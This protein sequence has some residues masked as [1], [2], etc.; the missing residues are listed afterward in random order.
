VGTAP[1]WAEGPGRPSH[2]V[3]PPGSWKP[4]PRPFGEFARALAT[5]YS[6]AFDPPG[7]A[8]TLPK[9]RHYQALNE[10]NLSTYLSP[11][12]SG[13]RAVSPSHYRA[14]LNDFYPQ[15]KSVDPGNMVL[16]AGTAPYGARPGGKRMPPLRFWR[17]L[18]CV[19][20]KRGRYRP[21]QRCANPAQVDIVA[22]HPITRAPR[23]RAAHAGDVTIP[24]LSQL[25]RVVRAAERGR[26]VLPAGRRPLWV[27][28]LWWETNPPDRVVRTSLRRQARWIAEGLYLIWKQ[29]IPV[30]IL[31]LIRDQPY[32]PALPRATFQS[33]VY[34]ENGR[35]KPALRAA[36]FPFVARRR[37]PPRLAVWGRSPATG[38]LTIQRRSAGKWRRLRRLRV[39]SG[40]VFRATVGVRGPA[41]LRARVAGQRSAVWRQGGRR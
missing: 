12:W 16:S 18:L 24:E 29:R 6:G 15:V 31:F 9:V 30:T 41:V 14:L 37:S 35:P 32:L 33:G 8:P 25:R 17:S 36:R 28:E 21:R 11:Q 19:K 22:H 39:Q 5:R 4:Y 27:T 13:R 40:T 10:P 7:A 26:N 20:R 3:A 23:S 34:F 2:E 38:R 1:T